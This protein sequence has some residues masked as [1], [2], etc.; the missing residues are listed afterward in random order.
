MPGWRDINPAAIKKYLPIFWAWRWHAQLATFVG[1]LAGEDNITVIGINPRGKTVEECFP[2]GAYE[3]V[4]ARFKR[5]IDGPEI[6]RSTGRVQLISGREG[7]GVRIVLPVAEDGVHADGIIGATVY[8]L[9]GRPTSGEAKIDHR[10]NSIQMHR[11][12]QAV[13]IARMTEEQ[14]ERMRHGAHLLLAANAPRDPRDPDHWARFGD[15]FSYNEE[16]QTIGLVVPPPV[17]HDH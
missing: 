11:L 8:R 3:L 9:G 13:L 12:V 16:T 10:N 6:M 5:V 17:R 15:L 2:A 1:R 7:R 4:K 14:R